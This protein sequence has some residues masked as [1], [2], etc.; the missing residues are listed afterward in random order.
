MNGRIRKLS[1]YYTNRFIN[2]IY[3]LILKKI[4]KSSS[5]IITSINSKYLL[6]L[7]K[8]YITYP[9][10]V[11][12]PLTRNIMYYIE[13]NYNNEFIVTGKAKFR[14]ENDLRIT[15]LATDVSPFV[16]KYGN[17]SNI[18]NLFDY[19]DIKNIKNQYLF[20]INNISDKNSNLKLRNFFQEKH[21]I[22]Y[23]CNLR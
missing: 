3:L 23:Q 4:K 22:T 5:Y 11:A 8:Q 7:N 2:K 1:L 6:L 18:F 20:C 19:K 15:Y 13:N 14:S 21:K 17:N 16:S 12:L 9:C 10:H